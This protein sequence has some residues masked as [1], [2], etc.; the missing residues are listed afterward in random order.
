[1]KNNPN[2]KYLRSWNLRP[3]LDLVI[4][5]WAIFWMISFEDLIFY[6]WVCNTII[7]GTMKKK[8]NLNNIFTTFR[9]WP[10]NLWF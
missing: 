9:C 10:K 6:I 2:S 4:T 1:M 8:S 5:F 3:K 7:A